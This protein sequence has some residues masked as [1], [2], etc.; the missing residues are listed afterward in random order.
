MLDYAAMDRI[1]R[2]LHDAADRIDE[3]ATS[4]PESVHAGP[5]PDRVGKLLLGVSVGCFTGLVHL[6]LAAAS[7]QHALDNYASGDYV[8]EREA[9]LVSRRLDAD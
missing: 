5:L 3:A 4:M 7:V 2:L 6:R 9:E 1:H 8:T